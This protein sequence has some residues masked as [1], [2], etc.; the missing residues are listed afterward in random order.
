VVVSRFGN[1]VLFPLIASHS[2]MPRSELREQLAPIRAKFLAAATISF[3]IIV[4]TADLPI[5]ILYDQRYQQAGWILPILILGSWFTVL[6]FAN[7][8]TLLGIGKPSYSAIANSSKFIF[9]LI[10]LPVG[11]RVAGLLGG[12]I[13]IIFADLWRYIPLLIG[14]KKER[15]SFGLQDLVSTLSVL[16]LIGFWEWVRWTLGFGSSFESLPIN[17]ALFHGFG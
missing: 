7:E 16:L 3:P 6:A 10:G 11:V 14:Q 1:Y 9:L 5:R 4:A 12:I 8:S 17:A 2:K 15:F 13:A